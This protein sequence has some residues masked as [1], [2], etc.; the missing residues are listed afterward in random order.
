MLYLSENIIY[1]DFL[2]NF[3]SSYSLRFILYSLEWY[4]RWDSYGH[5]QL[6]IGGAESAIY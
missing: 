5:L 3:V 2:W 6:T 4:Y 1:I